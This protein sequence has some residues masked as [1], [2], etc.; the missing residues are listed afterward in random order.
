MSR[1]VDW[2]DSSA[3]GTMVLDEEA[4]AL[5]DKGIEGMSIFRSALWEI[6]LMCE[7][8]EVSRMGEYCGCTCVYRK[9]LATR[10]KGPVRRA[11]SHTKDILAPPILSVSHRHQSRDILRSH[12]P[13]FVP[14]AR[15]RFINPLTSGAE[16][17]S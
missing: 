15:S 14:P 2:T 4:V 8:G 12:G 10:G 1:T 17:D 3:G 13:P 11:S 5:E 9:A 16:T 7:S 6:V